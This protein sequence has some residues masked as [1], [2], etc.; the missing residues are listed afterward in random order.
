M[1]H[2]LQ[3]SLLR[4][5]KNWEIYHNIFTAE[6]SYYSA[7][8]IRGGTGVVWGNIYNGS[9]T[10]DLR[11]D[12]VRSFSTVSGAAGKCDGT[13][14]WDGNT[15]GMNGYACRDQVGRGTDAWLWQDSDPYPP[16]ALLPAYIWL[17]R[18]QTGD[19]GRVSIVNDSDIHIQANRDYYNE[20]ASFDGTS[21]VGVGLYANRPANCTTGVAYWATDQGTWN[22]TVGGDQGLLYKCTSTNTWELYYTPYEYPHPLQGGTSYLLTL[23][24]AGDGSGVVPSDPAGIASSTSTTWSFADDSEVTLTATPSGDDTVAWSG[25][26]GAECTG[27]TCTVTMSAARAVTAT[28]T[29]VAPVQWVVTRSYVGSGTTSPAEGDGVVNDDATATTTQTPSEHWTFAGWSG[30]CGCT[31]TDSC[32]PTVTANCTIIATWTEAA[33]KSITITFPDNGELI[34]SDKCGLYC[35]QGDVNYDCSCDWYAEDVTLTCT[36]ATGYYGCTMTG[37]DCVSGVCTPNDQTVTVTSTNGRAATTNKDGSTATATV[38]RDG[39]TATAT[40]VR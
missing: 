22:K 31:G 26:D 39:S 32:A 13:S 36:P 24:I 37:D 14:M 9:Y 4:G 20:I 7:L 12:N 23:T 5:S 16:Q 19:I 6:S 35:G 34:T 25:T 1:V 21:G 18:R 40:I 11:F 30:T 33:K 27:L 2:S 3:D 28:F 29:N 17:N 38:N 10:Q 8:A 15:E